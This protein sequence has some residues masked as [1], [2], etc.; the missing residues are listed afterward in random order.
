MKCV[1]LKI[2]AMRVFLVLLMLTLL[3]WPFSVAAAV[4]CCDHIVVT[5][6]PSAQHHQ[7]AQMAADSEMEAL[8]TNSLGL[9]LDGGT[10]H[11]NCGCNSNCNCAANLATASE[12]MIAL[13]GIDQ[14]EHQVERILPPWH[15]RPYRPQ[16]SAPRTRG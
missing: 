9:D 16:W 13:T 4:D 10:C 8:A 5:Q 11:A 15:E 1:P 6:R 7:P 3:P 2:P 14:T 12:T